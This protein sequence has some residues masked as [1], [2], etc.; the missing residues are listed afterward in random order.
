MPDN[1]QEVTIDEAENAD[2]DVIG[3]IAIGHRKIKYYIDGKCIKDSGIDVLGEV[4][5][6]LVKELEGFPP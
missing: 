4:K 5:K 3:V 2:G 1:R 6:A